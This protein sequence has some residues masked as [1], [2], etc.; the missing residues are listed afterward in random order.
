[1]SHLPPALFATLAEAATDLY[2]QCADPWCVIGSAAARLLGAEVGVADVDVLTSRRDAEALIACWAARLE[3]GL[4]AEG[5]ERFRSRFARFRFAGLPLEVMGGLE[6]HGATGWQPVAAGPLQ[7]V[8]VHGTP[9][10]VPTLDAQIELC[11]AFGRDKD[12]Q[13]AEALRALRPPPSVLPILR[14]R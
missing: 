1:M 7:L 9:I 2:A 8:G 5:A 10:P 11:Q 6:L 13:H 4:P 14:V 12:R 3:P